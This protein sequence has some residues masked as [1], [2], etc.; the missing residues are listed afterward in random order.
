VDTHEIYQTVIDGLRVYRDDAFIGDVLQ[1]VSCFPQASMAHS[2]NKNQMASKRWLLDALAASQP[3]RLET[4]Y[5]LGGWYGVLAAM[6]FNDHRFDLGCVYS[7]DLDPNCQLIAD[8]LNQ[9]YLT[10]GRFTA[11]TRDIM[12]LH[13]CALDLTKPKPTGAGAAHLPQPDL[14]INTSC[15][16][17][18]HFRSWYQSLP[19]GV[20]LVL[21]SNDYFDCEEHVNCVADL[22]AFKRQAPLTHLRF[23]GALPLKRYT[24]FMLIGQK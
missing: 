12:T 24:R 13:F 4:T 5:V 20:L 10:Q 19:G 7:V 2:L 9:R 17:L 1:A 18:Q 11:L 14:I 16:H 23:A 15:E 8:T 22:E 21:Q 6:L 3:G